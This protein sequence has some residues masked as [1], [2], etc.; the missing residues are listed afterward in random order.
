VSVLAAVPQLVK[1]KQYWFA[2]TILEPA[3]DG[4]TVT[5]RLVPDVVSLD[6]GFGAAV[7]SAVEFV[8]TCRLM[9]FPTMG[10]NAIELRN[11][12]GLE[13]R[14]HLRAI[15]ASAPS[16]RVLSVKP[17]KWRDRF[18]GVIYLPDGSSAGDLMVASGYA[19]PWDGKG[20]PP[21][22]PW[23]IPTSTKG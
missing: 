21:T 15:L 20:A 18:E 16:L 12:G 22:P 3:H 17:D 13:A 11:S 8:K 7:T 2:G 6:I 19:I 1:P 9:Q 4:D 23:P 10:C 5:L 14:D